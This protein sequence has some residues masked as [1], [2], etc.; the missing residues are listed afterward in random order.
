MP[1]SSLIV[2]WP[3]GTVV[4]GECLLHEGARG[5]AVYAPGAFRIDVRPWRDTVLIQLRNL[6]PVQ[7]RP[8]PPER[9][10]GVLI[11]GARVATSGGEAS[12]RFDVR[13][14]LGA[15]LEVRAVIAVDRSG[16]PGRIR[17]HAQALIVSTNP[18]AVSRA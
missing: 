4:S 18:E 10:R 14:D 1:R 3:G 6:S 12:K 7:M 16:G 13:F 5:V 15:E 8:M 11:D 2:D 9:D 17:V